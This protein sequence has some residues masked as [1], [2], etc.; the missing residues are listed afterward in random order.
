MLLNASQDQS[1]NEDVNMGVLVC[2]TIP[3]LQGDLEKQSIFT[4]VSESEK[5]L[6]AVCAGDEG[7]R[8]DSA[9][10]GGGPWQ[11]YC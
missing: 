6:R 10:W 7:F 3:D 2:V 4:S 9:R 5:W 11:N 8:C 1:Q